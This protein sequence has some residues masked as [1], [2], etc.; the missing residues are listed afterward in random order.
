MAGYRGRS[1]RRPGRS[2]GEAYWGVGRGGGHQSLAH[3]G[4]GGRRRGA[5]VRGRRSGGNPELKW[6]LCTPGRSGPS[7]GKDRAERLLEQP[8]VGELVEEWHRG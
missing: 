5:L 7:E 6:Y 4:D 8:V 3:D 1:G 2:Q